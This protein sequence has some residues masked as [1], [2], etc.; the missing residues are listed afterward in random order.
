MINNTDFYKIEEKWQKAWQDAN[1]FAVKEDAKKKKCYVLEMYPYPSGEGLHIGHAFNYT[2]GDI[3][4]RFK[5]MNGFNVLHPMGYDS[6][7]LPAENAAIK[8]KSH[9]RTYTEK[10]I[11]QFI[12]QQKAFGL[13]YDWSRKVISHDPHYYKWDQWIFLKMYENGLVYKKKAAINWCQKCNTVLANEQVHDGKCWR[14]ENTNV[15]IK[16]LEQWYFKTTKYADEL[17]ESIDSLKE[18]PESVKAKQK[19]WIGKSYGTE[20]RFEI[21]GK[22]WTIFTTRPDTIYG[23]TFMVISAKHPEL[24]TLVAKEQKQEV[25][26]FLARI[27]STSEKDMEGLDKDGVF[28]GSYATNPVTKEKIPVYAGNFVVADY[29]GGMVMAVPAHDQRDFEFAKKYGISIRVVIEPVDGKYLVIEKSLPKDA[30]DNLKTFGNIIVEETDKDWGRFFSIAITPGKEKK[31]ITFLE[32]NLRTD[33]G[34]WYA[35]SMGS[36]NNVIFS[37][38]HFKVSNEKDLETFKRYG[39]ELGI[40]KKQLDIKL[41]S[42]VMQRAYTDDGVLVNSGEFNGLQNRDAIVKISEMLEKNRLGKRV[43]QYKLRDWLVSRQRFWGTPIPI[44]YCDKCG[45]VPVLEKELPIVLPDDVVLSD[46]GNPLASCDEFVNTKCPKCDGKAKRETDTMDTF[47]NSSWY[48][49]RYTDPQNQTEI[50]DKKKANYWMPIDMYI[51]GEEHA[52]MHLIYFRFYNKFLR[53]IGLVKA[54]E[55]AKRLFNQGMIHGPDGFVMSKSRGNVVDPLICASKYGADTTRLYLVSVA[56]PDKDFNWSDIGI[57]GTY[58]FINKIYHFFK[59]IKPSKSSKR[60]ESKLNKAIKEIT[61][62]IEIVKYN[63]AII[64]LRKLYEVIEYERNL[65]KKDVDAFLKLMSPFCPHITEELWHHIGNKDFISLAD[66]PKYDESKIDK[67]QEVLEEVIDSTCEDINNVLKVAK[68][69]KP[70]AITLIIA[71]DWKYKFMTEL[72]S[73][74]EKTIKPGEIIKELMQNNEFKQ[75]VQFITKNVPIL[76]N[77]RSK[78]P[79]EVLST[80]LEYNAFANVTKTLEQKYNSKIIIE[81]EKESKNAKAKFAMPGKPGV[82]IE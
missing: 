15:E 64:K 33:N 20:I 37:K 19:N 39:S 30:V 77:D 24:M 18:W 32:N 65:S 70:K 43:V 54:D 72:K 68:I 82:F 6:F 14:H 50:F 57:E 46:K 45:A 7:G 75:N 36:T 73:K 60:L 17:Y 27:K 78:M 44:V 41:G 62:D 52:C 56:S 2:I 28:T 59:E 53:D 10:A 76:V 48:Y 4:T 26:E 8:N 35:D 67:M 12:K 47:V 55:P 40:P 3:Y 11:E 58:K 69:D 61:H 49:L 71:D 9:P 80:D 51:G 21:N 79:K 13:T 5:L 31:I 29:A 38:T 42:E 74:L 66:W 81:K 22:P 23:V 1:I 34:I 16:H 63:N 25:D